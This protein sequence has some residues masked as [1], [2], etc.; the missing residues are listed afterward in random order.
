MAS[1]YRHQPCCAASIGSHTNILALC[2]ARSTLK[3]LSQT[4]LFVL[5]QRAGGN[6]A[7]ALL[8]AVVTNILALITLP[9]IAGPLLT[10]LMPGDVSMPAPF[11]VCCALFRLCVLPL[12]AGVVARRC[13]KGVYRFVFCASVLHS[14]LLR[15]ARLR[16]ALLCS[17]LL[18]SALLCSALLFS[19]LLCCALL[20][21]APLRSALLCSRI[22]PRLP[23]L[24]KYQDAK[25]GETHDNKV[26]LP[27][28]SS[29]S[30]GTSANPALAE[31]QL[32]EH[33]TFLTLFT[34][35]V[36]Q[37]SPKPWTATA[38]CCPMSARQRWPRRRGWP[39]AAAWRRL[40]CRP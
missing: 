3:S 40:A 22:T 6:T 32:D 31:L 12:A 21:S 20:C 4:E 30:L 2:R 23:M 8:T 28:Q 14:A 11:V 34:S 5:S 33:L 10:R 26:H 35:L 17:A 38:A 37:S 7:F 15:S 16:S 39:S 13:F 36:L 24:H 1:S 9:V 18:R 27:L 25:L 19:A 29:L